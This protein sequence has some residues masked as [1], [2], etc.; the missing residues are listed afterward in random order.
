MRKRWP[1][2]LGLALVAGAVGFWALTRPADLSAPVQQALATHPADPVRGEAVFWAAGCSGC[3]AAPGI[4]FNAPLTDRLVLSGGRRFESG[5]GTFVAPNISND[6][7]EGIG[8]WTLEEFARAVTLGVSPTNAHYYPAFPYRA[9][10]AATPGDVADLWAFWQQL[11]ADATPSQPHD[12]PAPFTLRRAL[13]LW[14]LAADTTTPP[15][16]PDDP[17]L[18]RGHYLTQTLAHCAECHTPR[19]ALGRLDTSQWMAGAPNPSGQGRIPAIPPRDW[20]AEDI[21]AY[22]A[23]GF[24]PAF[25]VVGG[26]MADVVVQMAQLDPEDRDAIAAWLLTLP[27][28]E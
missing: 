6:T 20:S 16:A 15:P 8:G 12:L 18:A 4:A 27:P 25:D 24:T 28:Q 13:G 7:N 9:Y 3:H 2:L 10:A 22:L 17:V 21:A 19:D 26:S 23:S 1:V 14:K 11:P 5:F